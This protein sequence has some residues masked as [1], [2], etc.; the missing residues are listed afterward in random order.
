MTAYM[1]HS[2]VVAVV[3][4]SDALLQVVSVKYVVMESVRELVSLNERA[5]CC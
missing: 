2:H 1:G 5:L 4:G 3:K